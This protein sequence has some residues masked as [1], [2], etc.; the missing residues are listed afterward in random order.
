[1]TARIS[2]HRRLRTALGA[3][4]LVLA[5]CAAWQAPSEIRDAAIRA[6][7]VTTTTDDVRVSAAVLSAEDSRRLFGADIN[8]TGVQPV[9]IEVENES[10]Q[11]LWLLRT[12]VDPDYFSP[13]EV[14]WSVHSAFARE[15]NSRIDDH[16]DALGFSNPIPAGTTRAGVVF[17]NPQPRSKILNLD[18]VGNEELISFSL[19]VPVPDSPADEQLERLTHRLDG[20][21]AIDYQ[22]PAALR[23]ALERLPCCATGVDGAVRGD[24]LN[25]VVVGDLH[26]VLAAMI[27]RGFRLDEREFDAQERLYARPPDVVIRKH[28]QGGASATRVRAWLAPLRFQGNPVFLAQVGRPQGGRFPPRGAANPRLHPAVDEARDLL[29]QDLIYSGGLIQLG[30]VE[31]VGRVPAAAPGARLAGGSYYTDGLRAVLFLGT[32]PLGLDDLEVL[33]WVPYFERLPLSRKGRRGTIRGAHE[34]RRSRASGTV[35]ALPPPRHSRGSPVVPVK[36]S[37]VVVLIL[38]SPTA[39]P[40]APARESNRTR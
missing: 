20:A 4:L 24:P 31:G 21:E 2:S 29:V 28:A 16:F 35:E 3:S 26:D 1:V 14:A 17:T 33:D 15:T 7:A 9:W 36:S 40:R 23:A 5:G 39:A 25:L 32:R 34:R 22:D 10:A 19:F 38:A 27:R 13:L 37:S 11:T 8:A 30:F 6:R 18:L 12:G